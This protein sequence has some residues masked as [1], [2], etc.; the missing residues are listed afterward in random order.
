[1][2]WPSWTI[3]KKELSMSGKT[4]GPIIFIRESRM[5]DTKLWLHEYEHVR[6]WWTTFG[7]HPIFYSLSRSYRLR[8]EV[9]A[10]VHELKPDRSNLHVLA[11]ALCLPIYKLNITEN[12]AKKLLLEELNKRRGVSG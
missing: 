12:Q 6:Q 3:Y 10:Y 4:Y 11:K 1:M 9:K 7:L 5:E 8:S 2:R